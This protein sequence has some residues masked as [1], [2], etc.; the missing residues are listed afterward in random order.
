MSKSEQHPMTPPAEFP[1]STRFINRELSWLSFNDRVLQ[2]AQNTKHPLL[3]RVR[4]LS[5]SSTNLDEFYMVR[6]AGLNAQVMAGLNPVSHDGL[7]AREQLAQIDT[8]ARLLSEQQLNTWDTLKKE[9]GQENIHI[10]GLPD[11]KK[12]EQA[13]LNQYFED[14]IFPALTPLAIDPA[15]PFPF[16][17]NGG[18]T[19]ALDLERQADKKPLKAL[20][21]IPGNLPRFVNLE[22]ESQRFLLLEKAIS[23]Y[24]EKLFPGFHV[25][26]HG[27]FRII[28][29][30][31]ME[32]HEEAD[33]LVEVL[34]SSL[35]K[36]QHGH[37]I[38]LIVNHKM[39]EELCNFLMD[40]LEV[41]QSTLFRVNGMLGLYAIAEMILPSRPDLCFK[42]YTPRFPERIQDFS[43]NCF[44]AIRHKDIIVHHP[45]E[46]FDVVVQFLRQAALDPDVLTIKQTLYRT[47]ED[48]PIV[49]ALIEAAEAGKSVTAI[50]ELKARF[51]EETNI[52]L[53][54]QLERAGVQVVFGFMDLKTHAKISLIV[55]REG[56]DVKSYVHF[57]TGNYHPLTAKVYTDLSY[58]TTEPQLCRDAAQVFN[59]LTGYA[60]PKK[61]EKVSI[62]PLTLF[63]TLMDNIEEEIKH[64]QQKKPAAI[65]AKMNS[66]VD[67]KV[68]EALYRA[69]QAGVQVDLIIRGVCCLRP[70]VPGLSENIRVKSIV[71]R[72]L[73]HSRIVCFGNGKPLPSD[74]AKVY[75]SSADWM[76]RN[77]HTRVESLVPIENPTVHEQVL[78]QIMIANLND[79]QQSWSLDAEGHY[80]RII[81]KNPK[82]AFTAVEYFM[83]NPSLSG[84]GATGKKKRKAPQLNLYINDN[85]QKPG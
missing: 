82:D 74:Q 13:W 69:S 63:T 84:Q 47:S 75:I 5:I 36:R 20:V 79:N 49:R 22:G 45:Y 66:L 18:L 31:E 12:H 17:P 28:R 3:E 23:L 71:G 53:A 10:I 32:V 9:L 59:Y 65:W 30:S 72:F 16:I 46:S 48:S 60:I 67:P 54:S 15:H 38:R 52:R 64:A 35:K 73:E 6:V 29:D 19:I 43:G 50:I 78:N 42:T 37:I 76:P 21:R 14:N 62:S 7:T 34:K 25:I 44:A 41:N 40:E 77:F 11:L 83:N 51:D 80:S 58:F 57:G 56:K 61:L 4:F 55:R 26:E 70:G 2:E 1:V 68:I 33:D 85:F 81:S 39:P 24:F 8:Q 27:L